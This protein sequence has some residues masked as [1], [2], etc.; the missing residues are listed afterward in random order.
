MPCPICK[1]E[2]PKLRLRLDLHDNDTCCC[3]PE[4]CEKHDKGIPFT[5]E[6]IERT[7]PRDRQHMGFMSL[8]KSPQ[9][10]YLSTWPYKDGVDSESE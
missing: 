3:T 1:K 8:D 10:R 9:F 5:K 2:Y 4:M 6:E 7:K